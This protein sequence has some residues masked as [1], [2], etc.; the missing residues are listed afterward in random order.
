MAKYISSMKIE[1]NVSDNHRRATIT[2]L[3]ILS[4]IRLKL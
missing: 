2:F 4:Q 3:E 1:A